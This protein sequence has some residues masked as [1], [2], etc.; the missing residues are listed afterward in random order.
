[1]SKE[2]QRYREDSTTTSDNKSSKSGKSSKT[3]KSSKSSSR[4]SSRTTTDKTTSTTTTT[5]TTTS[6][7]DE[8]N[9]TMIYE[10]LLNIKANI[11]AVAQGQA[12]LENE[13]T[14]LSNI[15]NNNI[16]VSVDNTMIFA[17]LVVLIPLFGGAG[18]EVTPEMKEKFTAVFEKFAAAKKE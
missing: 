16:K 2:R 15:G 7:K 13:S 18:F 4:K 5:T 10:L 6:K 11:N 14:T 9:L 1:M 3:G 17:L 8:V 12:T